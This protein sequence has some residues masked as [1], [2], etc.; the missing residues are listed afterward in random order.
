MT[1]LVAA[2]FGSWES[3]IT[4]ALIARGDVPLGQVEMD[5][6]DLYWLEGRPQEGG[7]TVLMRQ[8]ADGT[9]EEITPSGFNVRTRVHEYGGG[10]YFVR[11][12]T[13]WFSNFTD[14][15]LYR[16]EH[17]GSPR[18]ITP[19]PLLPAGARYADGRL[20]PDGK[21]ILCI[22]ELHAEGLEAVNEIVALPAD[23]S[24]EPRAVVS[25]SDFYASPRISPDGR[26]LAWLSWDHPRMPWDGT[27]LWVA[28]LSRDGKISEA[29]KVAGGEAES[30]FQPEWG[31]DGVL[32]FVSD[33]TGWWN[34][35]RLDSGKAE[36]LAPMEAEFGVPQWVFGLSMYA[37]LGNDVIACSY[38][39]DGRQYL[40]TVRGIAG[41][42]ETI[43]AP[44]TEYSYVRGNGAGRLAF[45]AA[46]PTRSAAV[47]SFDAATGATEVLR[48]GL[49]FDLDPRC[50]SEARP[51]EFPAEGG[52]RAFALFYP[53]V[54]PSFRG[55]DGERPP[56]IVMSHGGPTGMADGGLDT[57]I[58]FWTSR[59][60]AVVDVNYGGSTGYGRSYR[61]RLKG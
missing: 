41:S 21:L 53:P 15:R 39:N 58:Q 14:Q 55:P 35:Y 8:E 30:I 60:I 26:R 4:A 54:N 61:E 56:L 12:G 25:G 19:S 33:R 37:F 3:P 1:E 43:H 47:V 42:V 28:V 6:A 17:G 2:P 27:L 36:A 49:D 59:G 13:V 16:Q 32:H 18:P 5:G 7:R 24:A 51:I 38:I 50:V 40:G 45:I 11:G 20:T 44:F 29:R 22:R 57:G 31:P 48:S 46:S 52:K 10:S 23:G 34:L 9:R